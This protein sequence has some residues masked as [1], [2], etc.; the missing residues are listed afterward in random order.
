M[1]TLDDK[2]K[3]ILRLLRQDARIPFSQIGEK[4]GLSGPAVADRVN[5]LEETG[6]ITGYTIDID[7]AQLQSGI[8]VL[9][10]I[11]NQ[12][13]DPNQLKKELEQSENVEHVFI[14]A[15]GTIWFSAHAIHSRIRESLRDLFESSDIEF[16]VTVVD[17][18]SWMPSISTMEFDISCAECG[19]SVD[20]Q[21]SAWRI[22]ETEYR[23]CCTSC[24]AQFKERYHEFD[25]AA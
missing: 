18:M 10:E 8:P 22:D 14:T 13:A 17:E 6:I 3:Q 11:T 15:N 23:F 4:I 2:D 25:Q 24:E 20:E 21:G 12:S 1:R 7:H 16:E 19:N 5:R 9:V